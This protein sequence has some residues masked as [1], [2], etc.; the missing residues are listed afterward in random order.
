M[1][2]TMRTDKTG[3]ALFDPARHEVLDAQ[4]WDE[5]RARTTIEWIVRGTEDAFVPQTYW[6]MHPLDSDGD[7]AQTAYPL[8]FGACGVILALCYLEG[9]GAVRLQRTYGGYLD[10]LL[11]L[12]RTWLEESDSHDYA[13]Y[14]M[15]E[16]AILL[17]RYGLD[18]EA[19]CA[20][21]LEAL[22]AANVDN[23][24][25]EL[26]WGSPGT[27]L[28]ALFLHERT[29]DE[30]WADLYRTL[31]RRLWSELE[32]WQECD[33]RGWTQDMYGRSTRY[34]GGVHG[35][36][37]TASV[38]IRGRDLLEGTEWA[39][40]EKCIADTIE[41]TAIVD[42]GFANWPPEAMARG[43][44]PRKML[45]QFCHGAPGVITCVADHPDRAL[46]PLLV[47][48]GDTI[49]DAGP[50][51][52]G[53]NLCHGTGGNGYAFLKLFGRTGD[54]RWLE[55]ARAFAMHGIRQTEAHAARYGQLRHSLWTGDPGFAVYLWDCIHG[56]ARFPT[57]DVF[58]AG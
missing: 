10:A 18:F 55:R 23:P 19:D 58:F 20:M 11:P 4:Q 37:A 12:T 3:M 45:M 32:W 41:R 39:G 56:K 54:E 16:T 2:S 33:C 14:L 50:L 43:T 36:A 46:D 1:K 30:R 22:I 21:R 25:R 42:G 48:G 57:L 31:V 6:P 35:F 5:A 9:V 7:G 26:M 53:S 28:A 24:A 17:L 27:A 44:A 29:G 38:V 13:S 47:A 49:W 40:W 15:G 52:K 51:A 8:Y 34:V